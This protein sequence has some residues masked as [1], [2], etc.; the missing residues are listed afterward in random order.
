MVRPERVAVTS[1]IDLEDAA[2]AA[3]ADRH[4]RRAGP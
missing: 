2:R 3:A 1:G 4:A